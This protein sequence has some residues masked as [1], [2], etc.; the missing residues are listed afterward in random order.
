MQKQLYR[1]FFMAQQP[2]VCQGLLTVEASRS[3]SVRHTTLG[4]TSVDG[5]SAQLRDLYLTTHYT[6]KRKTLMPSAGFEPTFPASELP[7]THSLGRAPTA[8][9]CIQKY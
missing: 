5:W 3:H 8:I 2:V 6:H 7:Q 9:G 4:R 1:N